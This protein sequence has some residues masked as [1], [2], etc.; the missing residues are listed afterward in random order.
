[1]N[2]GM[3]EPQFFT[4]ESVDCEDIVGLGEY[5]YINGDSVPVLMSF[6]EKCWID[7]NPAQMVIKRTLYNLESL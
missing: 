6:K 7:P 1:M 4:G 2:N 3:K 5:R